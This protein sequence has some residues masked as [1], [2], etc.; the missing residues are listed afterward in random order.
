MRLIR[1]SYCIT[2]T[3]ARIRKCWYLGMTNPVITNHSDCILQSSV[4]GLELSV[5]RGRNIGLLVQNIEKSND[6]FQVLLCRFA[7]W[8]L[9]Y[10]FRPE[11]DD[12][13]QL[14]ERMLFLE[15]F[16]ENLSCRDVRLA[17]SAFILRA[18]IK[19]VPR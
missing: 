15:I 5:P 14:I 3:R 19:V 17:I 8:V 1:C 18:H 6:G 10:V 13:I 9:L 4:Y 11:V 12:S 2:P 16:Q 7:Q